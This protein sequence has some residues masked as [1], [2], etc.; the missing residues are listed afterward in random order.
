LD[1][2]RS[3]CRVIRMFRGRGKR[4]KT[5]PASSLAKKKKKNRDFLSPGAIGGGEKTVPFSAHGEFSEVEKGNV[6]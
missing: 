3:R 2:E 4:R 6:S 5:A 1:R